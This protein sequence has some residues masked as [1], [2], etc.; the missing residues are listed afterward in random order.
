MIKLANIKIEEE[1]IQNKYF[2]ENKKFLITF[3]KIF[4]I[5][6]SKNMGFY[7][8]LVYIYNGTLPLVKKGRYLIQNAEYTNSL[9]EK[10]IFID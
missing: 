5:F 9:I 6:Y 10:N 2:N 7:A 4:Q 3:N 8:N 1:E